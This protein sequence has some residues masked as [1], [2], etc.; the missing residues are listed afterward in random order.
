MDELKFRKTDLLEILKSNRAAHRDEFETA[1]AGYEVEAIKRLQDLTRQMRSGK[2]P[3]IL[4]Q[5]AVPSDHTKDYDRV[6]RML[7]LS[8]E[9]TINLHEHEFQQYIQDDWSWKGQF[10][11][12][13]SGYM[14]S[15]SKALGKSK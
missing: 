15:G 4:I 9:D 2:R 12:S 10:T 11:A 1:I 6:I 3:N 5:M 13:N 7:E 14:V 8:T